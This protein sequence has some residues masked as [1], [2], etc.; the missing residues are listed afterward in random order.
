MEDREPLRPSPEPRFAVT[1]DAATGRRRA[2]PNGRSLPELSDLLLETCAEGDLL[3]VRAILAPR[4]RA[5]RALRLTD[6]E[7]DSRCNKCT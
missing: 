1:W 3:Q 7:R 4:R 2:E 5:Y 6:F